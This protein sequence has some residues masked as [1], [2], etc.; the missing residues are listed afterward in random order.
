MA[1]LFSLSKFYKFKNFLM[2]LRSSTQTSIINQRN[3]K[4]S[5]IRKSNTHTFINLN[6]FNSNNEEH[7]KSFI[8]LWC[9]QKHF[10]TLTR[11]LKTTFYSSQSIPINPHHPTILH[12]KIKI[13]RKGTHFDKSNISLKHDLELDPIFYL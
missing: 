4:P 5:N 1:K 3:S 12:A 2:M 13:E 6:T 10:L 8:L 7:N 9:I 11:F